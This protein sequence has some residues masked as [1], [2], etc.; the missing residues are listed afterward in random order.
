MDKNE[1]RDVK[2]KR[3]LAV[4]FGTALVCLLVGIVVS[5]VLIQ[6]IAVADDS[7]LETAVV[8]APMGE[9]GYNCRFGATPL[10]GNQFPWV[11]TLKLG[12]HL[13]FRALPQEATSQ[14]SEFIHLVS[15]KQNMNGST[16]LPTYTVFPALTNSNL[17]AIVNDNPGKLWLLGNEPDVPI[18]QGNTFPEVY[19]KAYHE[20]YYFIKQ[21]DPSAQVA[22]GGLSMMTPGRLQYLDIVWDTYL[23]MF[24]EP[25]PVDVWNFHLYI[26]SEYRAQAM[27][28][29]DGKV[30]LGTDPAIAKI[31]S[32]GNPALCAQ[33]KVYCRA[34]HD[35]LAIFK[36][37]VV[38]LRTWMKEHG[39]QDKPLILSEFSLLYPFVD[40]DNSVNP[41]TCFLMDE[42]GKCFTPERVN[43]FMNA[44]VS[45]LE[46]AVDPNLGYPNDE[47]R[48]VQQWM[49]FSL[50]QDPEGSGGSSR[51]LKDNYT[52][53]APGSVNA[54]NTVGQNYQKI[55]QS[56]ATYVNLYAS[57]AVSAV[58]QS[59]ANGG[60]GTVD[61]TVKF[62]NNGNTSAAGP[63]EVK[64]YA[65]AAMTQL[66]GTAVAT[67]D[68][69]FYGCGRHI[70]TATVQWSGLTA[71]V[72]N[73]W[74]KI[75][76]NNAISESK[77]SDNVAKGTVLID[78]KQIH[79]PIVNR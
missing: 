58:G 32:E 68:P 7:D 64:F 27:L 67:H 25:M 59:V 70:Y 17:G 4:F 31:S 44:T 65:N 71:G 20:V 36:E 51:L 28:P 42:N 61:L 35:S 6:N 26:L 1:K 15:I 8:D 52:S 24:N 10:A 55:I 23:E 79:I 50:W 72:R 53:F 47:N 69:H 57:E 2:R 77:T 43:N 14:Q 66:I 5:F 38:G 34:E 33:D 19:A 3:P 45:Y 48:L 54:L 62:L 46:T 21:R 16:Y 40:Y 22:I 41:T 60:T 76:T 18:V 78:P 13:N 12:W 11:D 37:Q 29:A 73:Y 75:N 56:R 74:V 63:V 30:A 9:V 49:W 39:Q